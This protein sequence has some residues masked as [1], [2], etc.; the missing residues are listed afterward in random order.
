MIAKDGA[1]SLDLVYQPNQARHRRH[2]LPKII[3]GFGLEKTMWD[4]NG[5]SY[6]GL[7]NLEMEVLIQKG[8][9]RNDDDNKWQNDF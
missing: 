5:C 2:F 4:R 3:E 8:R 7:Q 6:V 1:G 9:E